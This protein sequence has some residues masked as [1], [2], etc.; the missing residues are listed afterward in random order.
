MF[1]VLFMFAESTESLINRF[2]RDDAFHDT[3]TFHKFMEDLNEQGHAE[4]VGNS[5]ATAGEVWYIPHFAVKHPKKEKLR[6]VFD[7]SA[8]YGGSSINDKLLQGPNLL[9]SLLGILWRFR[10]EPIAVACDIE[11][12]YYNFFDD[13][14]DR[15]FL[16][17]LWPGKDGS[18]KEYRM[19]VHL[20]VAVF[21]PSVASYGLRKLVLD[22]KEKLKIL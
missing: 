19:T 1:N 17:F 16:R 11:K 8:K 2:K 5:D 10:K 4:G 18:V 13:E 14:K 12:M 6:V 3:Y 21:S 20:S 9:N 15:D 22:Q 7:C